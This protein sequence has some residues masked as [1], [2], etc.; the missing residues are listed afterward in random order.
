MLTQEFGTNTALIEK[1]VIY[2][3]HT[4]FINYINKQELSDSQKRV[5]VKLA[6]TK[7]SYNICKYLLMQGFDPN[8]NLDKGGNKT[9]FDLSQESKSEN[10]RTLFKLYKRTDSLSNLI[11]R[12]F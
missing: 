7:G 3:K 5:L 11:R 6:I 2:D 10:I 1:W 8:L 4:A 9:F 12:L